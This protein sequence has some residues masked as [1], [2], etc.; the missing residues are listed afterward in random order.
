MK[1]NFWQWLG[2]AL[3]IGGGAWLV[4]QRT[5][6]PSASPSGNPPAATQPAR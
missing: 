3:L 5:S 6:G 2:V 1:L 4:Y